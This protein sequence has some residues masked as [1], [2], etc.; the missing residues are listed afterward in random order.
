MAVSVARSHAEA[1]SEH[2]CVD[3]V[4]PFL[5]ARDLT[6]L[7]STCGV[8]GSIRRDFACA[9]MQAQHGYMQ[10]EG[11]CFAT[12]TL[13]KTLENIPDS[14]A[15]RGLESLKN[16]WML[17]I[18]LRRGRYYLLVFGWAHR[19]HGILDLFFNNVRITPATGCNWNNQRAQLCFYRLLNIIIETSGPQCLMGES[20]PSTA[21]GENE[22]IERR[23]VRLTRICF[24]PD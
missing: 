4:G 11:S 19:S 24:V 14:C 22:D 17:R 2:W 16:A 3:Y 6:R 13:L 12:L 18:S 21:G 20:R 9:V 15:I 8:L 10:K 7:T 1:L 23:H 5:A